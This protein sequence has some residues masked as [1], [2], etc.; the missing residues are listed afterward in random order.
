MAPKPAEGSLEEPLLNP[1]ELLD[2]ADDEAPGAS[3]AAFKNHLHMALRTTLACLIVAAPVLFKGIYDQLDPNYSNQIGG[4]VALMVVFTV[5]QNLGLTLQLAW[6][7][8][9]G[10]LLAAIP[11]HIICATMP[12]GAGG[13]YYHPK[14]VH[15]VNIAVIYL[16]LFLNISLNIRLFLVCWHVYF[17]IEVMNPESKTIYNT[18]WGIDKEAY[19]TTVMVTSTIGMAVAVIVMIVPTCLRA[20]DACRAQGVSVVNTLTDLVDGLVT[21]FERSEP[22]VRIVQLQE[23]AVSLRREID[24]MQGNID[25]SWWET[26]DIGSAGK[27]RALLTRHKAQ[28]MRIS[29][30]VFSLQVCISKED[31]GETHDRIMPMISPKVRKLIDASKSCLMASTT[32]AADGSLDEEEASDMR[33]KIAEVRVATAELA[34]VFN[35]ARKEVMPDTKITAEL[36]SESFFVYC[37]S[38]YARRIGDYAQELIE[39]P[40]VKGSAELPYLYQGMWADFKSVFDPAVILQDP[41]YRSFTYRNTLSVIVAF[42]IGYFFL[43]CS[44]VPAG[45]VAVLIS[46]FQGSALQKNLGRLQAVTLGKVLP[47][48]IIQAMGTMCGT[49]RM[50]AQFF[51]IFLWEMLT[52]Y[53]YYSSA[54]YGYIGCLLAAQG[55]GVLIF[56]CTDAK[57]DIAANQFAAYTAICQSTIG[58]IC[59]TAVDLW[60]AGSTAAELAADNYKCAMLVI[61]AYFQACLVKRKPNG[62]LYERGHIVERLKIDVKDRSIIK[63]VAKKKN[64]RTPG[65]IFK[66]LHKAEVLCN[67]ANLEPRYYRTPWPVEYFTAVTKAAHVLR[68]NL[69]EFEH[70]LK[71]PRHD[72]TDI[73]ACCRDLEPFKRIHEDIVNTMDH[74]LTMVDTILKN[75]TGKPIHSA[76]LK[77]KELEQIDKLED[78]QALFDEL[79]KSKAVALQYP[80]VAPDTLES[81]LLCRLNVVFMIM[82]STV[83]KVSEILKWCIRELV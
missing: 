51:V 49:V 69:L 1:G 41:G 16:G 60:L 15:A 23:V 78:M 54:T 42:Y 7:G 38:I 22:S 64:T 67:E 65:M 37:L 50:C 43:G 32:A 68:A 83:E 10:T 52:S 6:Q 55:L 62:D 72:Y 28:M 9:V 73:F 35:D 82:E 71:G 24:S 45:T 26:F 11:T 80:D 34:T 5:Y 29:D 12:G 57:A 8:F 30:T 75:D 81:D 3:V 14:M 53:I 36:Q 40:P 4:S 56:P 63:D 77:L 76:L 19:T 46:N 44:G 66:Y 79:N 59:M 31:F 39:H 13:E 17:I 21:Y 48:I 58:V 74:V 70:V 25:A 20:V 61:D 2:D 33:A 27:S 47:F 18:G